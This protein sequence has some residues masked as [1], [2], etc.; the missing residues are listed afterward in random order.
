[1]KFAA[2]YYVML[3]YV[4]VMFKPLI[5]IAIDA[6][7]HTFAEAEH[8]NEVHL[9]YGNDHLEK[10]LADTNS[11]ENNK[12]QNTVKSEDAAPVH[13]SVAQFTYDFSLI[14]INKQYFSLLLH[15]LPFIF[16]LKHTPPPK[17]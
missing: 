14:T 2:A 4:S 7:S 16:I 5:P 13:I 12:D 3:L 11:G 10:E 6:W 8:I 17:V 15:H 9:K 1:M